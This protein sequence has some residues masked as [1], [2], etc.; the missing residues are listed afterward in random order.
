VSTAGLQARGGGRWSVTGA[1]DFATV[2]G[3]WT[4]LSAL[5]AKGGDLVLSLSS[6]DS[7]NSA[8]MV[9]LLEARDLARRTGCRLELVDVPPA[10]VDL[11]SM[12]QAEDLIVGQAAGS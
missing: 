7:A 8:G 3:V 5:I 11:A 2:P 9:L 12:S 1:L 6:V 4:E 10:L